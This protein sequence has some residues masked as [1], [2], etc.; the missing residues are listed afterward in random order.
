M[1]T[2][3]TDLPNE[4]ASIPRNGTEDDTRE[5]KNIGET[6]K[7]DEYKT[8]SPMSSA[9]IVLVTLIRN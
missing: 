1:I 3:T 2:M 7:N 8:L 9:I 5:K 6:S 4:R